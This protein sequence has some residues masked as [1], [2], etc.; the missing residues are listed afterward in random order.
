MIVTMTVMIAIKMVMT[1]MIAMVVT[2]TTM[3]T[4][5]V[6]MTLMIPM[7]VEMPMMIAIKV[8]MTLIIVMMVV[9]IMVIP[10]TSVMAM[11]TS[12]TV[13]FVHMIYP[14]Q[15]LRSKVFSSRP[16]MP[17]YLLPRPVPDWKIVNLMAPTLDQPN[18]ILPRTGPKQF[19]INQK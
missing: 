7:V 17:C 14:V 15:V 9:T 8:A 3:N 18:Y 12:A 11:T 1:L 6:A 19:S 2:M 13:N 4:I 16:V 5:E 10:I